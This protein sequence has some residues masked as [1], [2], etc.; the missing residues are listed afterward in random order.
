[1]ASVPAASRSAM[2]GGADAQLRAGV[3]D[4]PRLELVDPGQAVVTAVQHRRRYP[5][6]DVT[7]VATGHRA[8]VDSRK[9]GLHRAAAVVT[10]H[11]DQRHVQHRHRVLDRAEHGRVDDVARGAHHEHVTQALVE[12]DLGSHPAVGAAEHHCGG[13]LP[14]GESG[15]VLDALAGMRGWPATNRSLPSLSAFHAVTG[16]V[17][18]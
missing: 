13:L 6:H 14:V 17:S 18:A 9:R 2:D 1:M 16:L 4:V 10:E 12:D 7:H 5:F 8:V 15:P 11:D 3:V